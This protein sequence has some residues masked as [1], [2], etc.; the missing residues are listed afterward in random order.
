[1]GIDANYVVSGNIINYA[2]W[3]LPTLGV[4]LDIDVLSQLSCAVQ[5]VVLSFAPGV[6]THTHDSEMLAA[7]FLSSMQ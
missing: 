1:M 7:C 3:V 4:S 6:I 2:D 5:I